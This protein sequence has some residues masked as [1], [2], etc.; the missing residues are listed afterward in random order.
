M[1]SKVN[2]ASILVDENTSRSRRI[3]VI[4]TKFHD[5]MSRFWLR[6]WSV[7]GYPRLD[8]GG[9]AFASQL[10]LC[11]IVVRKRIHVR[12]VRS[13]CTITDV[14]RRNNWMLATFLG[15]YHWWVWPRR[16]CGCLLRKYP[17]RATDRRSRARRW[18]YRRLSP[19][20]RT[21]YSFDWRRYVVTYRRI[22]AKRVTIW[23]INENSRGVFIRSTYFDPN[24]S[25]HCFVKNRTGNRL[26]KMSEEWLEV[27]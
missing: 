10:Q 5:Y 25:L 21:G 6:T 23:N 18:Y 11:R 20:R 17:A 19:A 4:S 13:S 2:Y 26:P 9:H 12:A 7:I 27:W 3:I 14:I 1:F 15:S 22:Y 24:I 16:V 8:G